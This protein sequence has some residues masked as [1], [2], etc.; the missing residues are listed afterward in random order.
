MFLPPP[1]AF[2]FAH[3][4]MLGWLAAAAVPVVIHLLSR[5]RYR[6]VSWAAMEYLLAAVRRHKRRMLF[7]Q[8]L[9]LA[10]RT[11]II[12]L[13]V[14][15][16]AE[17]YRRRT[18]LIFAPG[19]NTQRVLVF[20]GSY[21]MAYRPAEQSRFDRAK[22]L[23]RQIVENSPQGDAFT[24]LLMSSPPRAIVAAP[25]VERAEMLREIESLALPQS[26]A[27]LP[28][29]LTLLEKHLS[30]A[31]REN[32][33]LARQQ[34]FFL[35]DLQ[36]ITWE[37]QL[38]GAALTAFRRRSAAVA[39]RAA[40]V[41][42]DVGQP[43]A[44][45]LAVAALRAFDL[46]ALQDRQIHFETL[47][48]NFGGQAKSNQP[49]ELLVDGRKVEQKLIDVPPGPETAV[50]FTYRFIAPGDHAVEIHAPGDA[51]E[52][53]N[54]RWRIVPVRAALRVLCIDGRP[55]GGGIQGTADYVS[56]ALAPQPS[57]VPAPVKVEAAPES[58]LL[59][60]ELSH[61]DC[62]FLCNVA[63]FTDHEAR[64]LDAYLQAGG[65][66]VIL[67][68]DQLKP[69][70]YNR[71]LG[72][73]QAGKASVEG[74]WSM[75]ENPRRPTTN[76]Q[77]PTNPERIRLLPARIDKLV[78][79]D[80]YRL[81]P[82]GYRHPLLSAF[83]DHGEKALLTTPL[84]EYFKLDVP[85]DSSARVAL[86]A[87]GGDPLI[88][89]ETIHRGRV[90]LLAIPIDEPGTPLPR[91]PSF[92]PL[93]QEILAF[94]VA[95]EA[96]QHNLRVGQPLVVRLPEATVGLDAELQTPDGRLIALTPETSSSAAAWRFT[97]T[98]QS[99]IYELRFSDPA[100]GRRLYAVN[101]NPAEG[102]LAAVSPDRLRNDVWPG[103]ACTIQTTWQDLDRPGA[104]PSWAAP[105]GLQVELLYGVLCL[106]FF[107]TLLAWRFGH[108]PT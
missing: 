1:L 57:G 15:A 51:L 62:V 28:A 5:R 105:T 88:V 99:G 77:R 44:P 66:L 60:R 53:D 24:L 10:V 76:D 64:L 102:N 106:L 87:A 16:A 78:P 73:P 36:R 43:A 82:R 58:A 34:V 8:W 32:P 18:A 79:R 91:W 56:L 101:V 63:Q 61:Y 71:V 59:E 68:G 72:A 75:V 48:R 98:W 74:R 27:D 2:G 94:C 19:E 55:S 26:V 6:E 29:A 38:A 95:G 107:E 84:F 25:T 22:E 7:E 11:A 13:I 20:D 14:L 108:H 39:E 17:P 86:A 37:P 4:P 45:N 52:V 40:L 93:I 89:E 31:R 49:V 21:S 30:Q 35:T 47:L 12:I 90:V 67:P 33:R 65:N 54:R 96:E 41:V 9:L 42:L 81:D 83:R 46:P 3:L 85:K 97:E 70:R 100:R 23:A 103:V 50:D 104:T 92:L 80:R 69:D